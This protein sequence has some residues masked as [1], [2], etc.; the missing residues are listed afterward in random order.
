MI[1]IRFVHG[2]GLTDWAIQKYTWSYWNHVE[3]WTPA[4][5]LGAQPDGG[6]KVR[7]Y[8]YLGTSVTEAFRC[9]DIGDKEPAFWQ[10]AHAQIGKP[11]DWTAIFGLV[12]RRD[13]KEDDSWYCSEYIAADFA[14]VGVPIVH[15]FDNQSYKITPRDI[16]L[17]T[18]LIDTVKP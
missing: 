9:I 17:S 15:P 18:L 12:A 16:G 1:V 11:Y 3:L 7:P 14:Q 10:W 6:V 8:N 4:G 2:I 13:W 5:Y